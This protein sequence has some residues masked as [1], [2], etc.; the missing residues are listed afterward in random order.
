M[1][2]PRHPTQ[3]RRPTTEKKEP[4]DAFIEKTV[5]VVEWAKK[6]RQILSLAG[7]AVVVVAAGLVYYKNYRSNWEEQAVQRLEQVQSAFSF[8]D[9]EQAEADLHQYLSQFE[10]TVYALEARLVLG[11]ALLEDGKPDEAVEVLAP[12]VRE[13]SSQPIGVQAGFLLASAYEEAGRRAD[14]EQL[15][16]RIAN[17]TDLNFQVQEA[18]GEAAR[19]R[20]ED[21]DYAGAA[22][23]Y[24]EVLDA[25][26]DGDPQRGFWEMRLGEATARSRAS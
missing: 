24:R 5:A 10:G 14:A 16:L 25:L 4:E 3:R 23:L 17:T 2:Q 11:Q 26:D 15:Y 6:R 13:M 18:L 9:R 19:L 1:S 20:T 7:I 21:G 12:A 8:G 22:D